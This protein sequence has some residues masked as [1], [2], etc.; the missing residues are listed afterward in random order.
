MDFQELDKETLRHAPPVMPWAK[1]AEWI[2]MGDE[3]IVVRG[4]LDRGYL[5][6]VRLGKRLMVNV[7]RFRQQLMEEEN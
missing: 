6:S 4:W 7:E 1:F 3:P 2:Q 5:P